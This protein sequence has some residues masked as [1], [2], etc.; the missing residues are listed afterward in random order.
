MDNYDHSDNSDPDAPTGS[1][2][3]KRR[4]GWQG[5]EME[6]NHQRQAIREGKNKTV[7][8][9]DISQFQN[10]EVG[11]GYK[12][13][14]VVRQRTGEAGEDRSSLKVLDMSRGKDSI[15]TRKRDKCDLRD[16][17]EVR[18]SFIQSPGLRKFRREIESILEQ[19]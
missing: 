3:G 8:A 7:A 15:T 6:M 12:A 9:V 14:H 11:Q 10:H 4:R 2:V 19:T 1:K 17:N 18:A 13:K 5:E 16:I